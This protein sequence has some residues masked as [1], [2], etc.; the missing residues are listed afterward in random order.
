MIKQLQNNDLNVS[1]KIMKL[2]L[3]SYAIEAKLLK[4]INFPPLKRPIEKY[5][6]TNTTFYG[7]FENEILCGAIEINYNNLRTHINSLVV[8]PQHFRKGIASSLLKFTLESFE[9]NLF[10]VET[11]VDNDPASQLYRKFDFVVVK[12][13]D[14]DHGVRKVRFEKKI[15]I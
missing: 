5:I 14:T 4:A 3:S 12:Q 7:Y 1:E 10:M 15:K 11:G 6:N 2:F 13:W 8:D 9:S